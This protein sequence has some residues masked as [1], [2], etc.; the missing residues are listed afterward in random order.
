MK[1]TTRIERLEQRAGTGEPVKVT[2]AFFDSV[3]DGT[4]S[5][6]EFAR[7]APALREIFGRRISAACHLRS[8]T[9]D[10]TG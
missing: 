6:E 2:I 4:V 9:H 7:Y 3:L 8:L 1:L 10:R 5:D